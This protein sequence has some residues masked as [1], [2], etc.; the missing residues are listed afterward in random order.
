M[1]KS[2]SGGERKLLEER[3]KRERQAFHV[4]AEAALFSDDI[5]SLARKLL[6]GIM[7]TFDFE[8]GTI[9]LYDKNHEMLIPIADIGT[10][11]WL[12]DNKAR[13]VSIHNK[14]YFISHVARTKKAIYAPDTSSAALSKKHQERIKI[15]GVKSQ[16]AWPLLNSK[17]SLSRINPKEY[18]PLRR[19][20]D[21]GK[22]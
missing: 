15:L 7:A 2:D 14:D 10:K 17:K 16:V 18:S 4:V 13:P 22:E 21:G 20:L 1:K 5:D 9:R 12:E 3:Q 11:K 6:T 19:V 8:V